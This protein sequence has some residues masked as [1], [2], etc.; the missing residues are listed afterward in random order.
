[1]TFTLK[2]SITIITCIQPVFF[3]GKGVWISLKV[4]EVYR[5][6]IEWQFNVDRL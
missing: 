6:V 4:Y 2:L 5:I 3:Y 1:M